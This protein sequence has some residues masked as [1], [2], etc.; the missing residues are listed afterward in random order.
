MVVR[1]YAKGKDPTD[2]L[3]SMAET[4]DASLKDI[5]EQSTW[6]MVKTYDENHFHDDIKKYTA[7]DPDLA[8]IKKIRE[9]DT[10]HPI[11]GKLV[12]S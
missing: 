10:A 2:A 12:K 6:D 8:E 5:N 1:A 3:E 11:P 9:A 4:I 7:E